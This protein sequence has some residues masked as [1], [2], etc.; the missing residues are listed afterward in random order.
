MSFSEIAKMHDHNSWRCQA[1]L[2]HVSSVPW[3]RG[4][5]C[6]APELQAPS[7]P[8]VHFSAICCH[9]DS[10]GEGLDLKVGE[11]GLAEMADRYRMTWP[12]FFCGFSFWALP[13]LLFGSCG[14]RGAEPHLCSEIHRQSHLYF[15]T[16]KKP[17]LP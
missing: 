15:T 8:R 17:L 12:F 10:M 16:Q 3:V 5:P 4:P 1:Q 14:G 9:Q 11:H 7:T 13:F 6:Q 2:L